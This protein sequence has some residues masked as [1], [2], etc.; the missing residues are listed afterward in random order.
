MFVTLKM[1]YVKVKLDIFV[2]GQLDQFNF[3]FYQ[4]EYQGRGYLG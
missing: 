3:G 1:L 2:L 4:K